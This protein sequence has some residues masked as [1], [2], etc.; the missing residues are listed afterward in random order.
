[1][2]ET[3]RIASS[4]HAADAAVAAATPSQGSSFPSPPERGLRPV[5]FGR[6]DHRLDDRLAFEQQP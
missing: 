5:G 4:H 6:D 3:W 2:A 1:M